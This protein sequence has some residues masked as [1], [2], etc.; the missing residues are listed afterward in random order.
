[1]RRGKVMTGCRP[2]TDH[3][4]IRAWVERHH[5]HPA[6]V[7]APRGRGDAQILRIDFPGCYG[8][9]SMQEIPWDE[10]FTKFDDAGLALVVQDETAGGQHSNF[11]TFVSRSSVEEQPKQPQ[12]RRRI[13]RL[14]SRQ[15]P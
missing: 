8:E 5:G 14:A 7:T 13:R 1:M 6:S 4:E 3:E 15:R 9:R 2:L 11:N 10:F 12:H